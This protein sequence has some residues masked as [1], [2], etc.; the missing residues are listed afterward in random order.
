MIIQIIKFKTHAQFKVKIENLQKILKIIFQLQK[1]KI[2]KLIIFS[3]V[4][5]I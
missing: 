1:I 4:Y 3:E 2:L 5:C